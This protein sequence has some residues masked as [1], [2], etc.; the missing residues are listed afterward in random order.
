MSENQLELIERL[1]RIETLLER[2][3]SS[4]NGYVYPKVNEFVQ[5]KYYII[6]I[7]VSVSFLVSLA[8]AFTPLVENM[9]GVR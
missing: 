5:F 3:E 4:M 8:V 7:S 6:G 2:L 1:T 9:F